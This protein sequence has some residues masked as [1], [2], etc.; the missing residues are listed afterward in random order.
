[1]LLLVTT[2]TAVVLTAF[3]FTIALVTY[4]FLSIDSGV[5]AI[6]VFAS[7]VL[8]MNT[9]PWVTNNEIKYAMKKPMKV[10]DL[11]NYR[12]VNTD[13]NYKEVAFAVLTDASDGVPYLDRTDEDYI[14][15]AIEKNEYEI[16]KGLLERKLVKVDNKSLAVAVGT[17]NADMVRLLID[18][19]AHS[20][21]Y[22][23]DL[24]IHRRV[25]EILKMLLMAYR[26]EKPVIRDDQELEKVQLGRKEIIK[27]ILVFGFCSVYASD[28]MVIAYKPSTA[29][30]TFMFHMKS[31]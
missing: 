13:G 28:D 24:A 18:H 9:I 5:S 23:I 31:S 14:M 4:V 1:M 10:Q 6:T 16:L 17:E 20:D 21:E 8:L 22:A 11:D 12:Q 7:S 27:M 25:V 26:S 2:L 19:G 15:M 3:M 30:A 29:I